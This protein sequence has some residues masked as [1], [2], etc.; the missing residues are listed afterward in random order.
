MDPNPVQDIRKTRS[1]GPVEEIPVNTRRFLSVTRARMHNGFGSQS[2]FSTLLRYAG[3]LAVL[4]YLISPAFS[5]T[6]AGGKATQDT[7]KAC[8]IAFPSTWTVTPDDPATT[9]DEPPSS[10]A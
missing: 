2:A 9:S 3:L 6:P 4:Q 10:S 7:N 8:Q 1:N 5:Q